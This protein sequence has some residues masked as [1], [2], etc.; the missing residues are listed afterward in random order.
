MGDASDAP[1]GANHDAPYFHLRRVGDRFQTRGLSHYLAGH[2]VATSDGRSGDGIFVTWD[3][4]GGELLVR[5]DRYG[6][7]PLYYYA[8][9]D[10]IAI[11]PSIVSLVS[12]GAPTKLD[13]AALAVFLRLG[14]FIGDDTPFA[15]IRAL[16][17][18]ATLRWQAGALDVSGGPVLGKLGGLSRGAAIAAY[19][20]LFR[21]AVRRRLP[22]GDDCAVPL[23]GG[24]DSRHILLELCHAG[25]KPRSC[26]TYG[27]WGGDDSSDL[28][29]ARQVA[30][31]LGVDHVT[32]P[33]PGSSLRSE[34]RK[35]IETSFC[36]DEHAQ[37]LVLA[38]YLRGVRTVY[39][40]I[41]GDVLSA[42]LFLD[43]ERDAMMQSGRTAELAL[44]LLGTHER[45]LW[46][47]KAEQRARF[48]LERAVGRL[49]AELARHVDA[50]NP[51]GSFYF[52]NRTRR[53]IALA[54]YAL[55]RGVRTV[56][57]PYVDH[58]VFDLLS[59]LPGGMLLDRSFHT[60]ALRQ[61]HPRYA[62][63]PFAIPDPMSR[64]RR[65]HARRHC[66]ELALYLARGQSRIIAKRY[67]LLRL[68]KGMLAGQEPRKTFLPH[69]VQLDRWLA[70]ASRPA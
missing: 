46:L 5:N 70:Q 63:I 16:P 64:A 24:A 59:S 27:P 9:A 3:C 42:G 29:V 55:Y 15:E 54:P 39:D 30:E 57:A 17:P 8:A 65:A 11:S 62:D 20:T 60:E 47:L 44:A 38:D 36:A 53:E 40:G 50:P 35:N 66:S 13:D 12:L 68:L 31:A 21:Q 23:S 6:F 33:Q 34:L 26:V 10:E 32:L 25:V 7:H 56:F 4:D 48:G 14:F 37:Y 22:D 49:A 69:L 19:V 51:V 28:S 18:N 1:P 43:T 41:G 2:R 61:A 67:A 52:W 58:E 45:S